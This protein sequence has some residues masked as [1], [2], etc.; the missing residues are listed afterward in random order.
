MLMDFFTG[1][2]RRPKGAFPSMSLYQQRESGNVA[3]LHTPEGS[4]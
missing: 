1:E 4:C 2:C 3:H